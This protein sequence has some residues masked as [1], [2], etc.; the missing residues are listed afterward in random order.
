MNSRLI[1]GW[2]LPIQPLLSYSE[3]VHGPVTLLT[4]A[5]ERFD[6]GTHTNLQIIEGDPS[7][8]GSLSLE[9]APT[10]TMIA[11][12]TAS[13]VESSLSSVTQHFPETV[14]VVIESGDGRVSRSTTSDISAD[15]FLHSNDQVVNQLVELTTS[16]AAIRAYRVREVLRLIHGELAIFMHD[17]PD[18]DAIASG[19][20]VARLAESFGTPATVYYYGDITHQS[21][22]AFVNLLDLEFTHLESDE[23]PPPA[24]GLALVDH[25]MPGINNSLPPD[26]PVDIIF[27]HHT[28]SG[29]VE[30]KFVDLRET[31][32]ATSS[33]L[34]EY[35]TQFDIPLDVTL[36]TAL[37][38]G[39]QTDTHSLTRSATPV[40]FESA[41]AVLP[42]ADQELLQ[43]IESPSISRETMNTLAQSIRSRTVSGPI[44]VSSVGDISERDSLAQA[45]EMLLQMEGVQIT[46]VYGI[47]DD[48][49]YASARASRP[50]KSVDL[51][52]VMRDAFGQIGSA[53]GHEEMAGASIP[54]GV[55]SLRETDEDSNPEEEIRFLLENRFFEAVWGQLSSRRTNEQRFHGSSLDENI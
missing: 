32:G 27:D 46:M 29:P 47:T 14:C 18:P 3:S 4:E 51:A 8:V 15:V 16:P 53:G 52:E 17:N 45:A 41:K 25:S 31:V 6:V 5:A 43:R 54:I 44:A 10:V 48:V 22:R 11:R 13:A 39:I 26:T 1:L 19:I 35:L 50:G 40:D 2:D 9:T 36:A 55:L 28:P 12:S 37:L 7:S 49:I 23:S 42:L 38:Y 34:V 21:N 20:A 33:I 24:S 30:A